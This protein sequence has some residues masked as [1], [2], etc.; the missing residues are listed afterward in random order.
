MPAEPRLRGAMIPTF[1]TVADLR[2]L[3]A[4]G[5][6]SV[7][8]QLM[9]GGFPSY[10]ASNEPL[11]SY[12]AWMDATLQHLDT[13]LP[14]C[15]A[16]GLRIVLD[17]HTPPGGHAPDG[18]WRLFQHREHQEFFV[19]L[20][21]DIATRYRGDTTFWAFDL[22]NEPNEDGRATD[23]A[24]SW[25]EVAEETARAIRAV[26]PTRRLV[27][28]A[29]PN[30]NSRALAAFSP[31]PLSNIAYSFHMYDPVN[32]THQRI[33]EGDTTVLPY[34]GEFYGSRWGRR[35]LRQ[36][37]RPVR[38]WQLRYDVP[39]YVGE[40]SAVRWAP[41]A[42]RYLQD[43]IRIYERY[44]WHWAYHAWRESHV[45][46]IEHSSDRADETPVPGGSNRLALL[47][48]YFRKSR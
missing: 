18:K 13:M 2:D 15:R 32:F 26:D 8:W 30:G 40:F 42:Y 31:L 38:E 7:R 12:A 29:A 35:R 14:H 9:W 24:R 19:N 46:S 33:G 11:S 25:R 39:I 28:E 20:W 48:K 22:M 4:L 23:S 27:V 3:A 43:C 45:W 34:P 44:G 10:R 5:A 36:W 41:G 1:A 16:L 17:V 6:N 37:H 21:R 47:Q